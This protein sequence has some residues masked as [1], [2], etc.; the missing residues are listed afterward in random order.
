MKSVYDIAEMSYAKHILYLVDACYGGLTLNTRGLKKDTTPEYIMKMTR[1]RG[2]QVITAGGKDEQVIEKPEWGHSAFTRNLIKGLGEGF[3]DENDDGII[4]AD[5]LG[6]FIKNRVV[7]DVDGAHTPQKGRI[8]SD[9]GEFVFI[10]ETLDEQIADNTPSSEQLSDLEMELAEIKK[11]LLLQAQGRGVQDVDL[12]ENKSVI[13]KKENSN[14]SFNMKTASALAWVFPGMG[15][16]YSGR[17]GKGIL[18][19]G[20]EI[21]S[22]GAIF[23]MTDIINARSENLQMAIR[24]R[25]RVGVSP[26]VDKCNEFELLGDCYNY[27]KNEAESQLKKK[28]EAQIGRIAAGSAAVGIWLWNTRDVKKMKANNYS[29]ENRFSVGVNR[30]CHLEV[31]FR[32]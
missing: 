31:R 4:T 10:S 32:F 30:H 3:A 7:V 23:L 16:Y 29:H 24:N 19:T 26:F 15:H 17:A 25:D 28:N 20:L 13:G 6:G 22:I 12:P 2:R 1:E 9:M 14:Q 27:W 18:F 11:L 5:E 8:G 21:A